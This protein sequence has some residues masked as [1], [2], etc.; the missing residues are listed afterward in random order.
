MMDE[1]TKAILRDA[2]HAILWLSNPQLRH[3]DETKLPRTDIVE[4]IDDLLNPPG[5]DRMTPTE[6]YALAKARQSRANARFVAAANIL[7]LETSYFSGTYRVKL[8]GQYL[9]QKTAEEWIDHLRNLVAKS[10]RA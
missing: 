8:N 7:G 10:G 3:A 1:R 2:R 5:S 6:A 4:A 9:G